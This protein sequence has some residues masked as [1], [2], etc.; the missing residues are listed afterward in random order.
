MQILLLNS[1]VTLYWLG[2]FVGFSNEGK[3]DSYQNLQ[4]VYFS[5]FVEKI[6]S[7]SSHPKQN[8]KLSLHR[9]CDN[10][11]YVMLFSLGLTKE[12]FFNFEMW[13]PEIEKNVVIFWDSAVN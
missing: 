10:A 11:V 13:H 2:T 6:D 7:D 5:F 12:N 1:R 4:D 3:V 8:L 9:V